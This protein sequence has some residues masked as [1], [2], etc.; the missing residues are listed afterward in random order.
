MTV[1]AGWEVRTFSASVVAAP[2][3]RVGP[4]TTAYSWRPASQ[5]STSSGRDTTCE[6]AGSAGA[7]T[8]AVVESG[9]TRIGMGG[10]FFDRWRGLVEEAG[11]RD[12]LGRRHL[13]LGVEQTEG[14]LTGLVAQQDLFGV[15]LRHGQGQQRLRQLFRA[16]GAV[17]GG[18]RLGRHG[19]GADAD[20]LDARQQ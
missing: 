10:S 14:E 6:P 16:L 11:G 20:H 13:G 7:S 3:S 5:P 12:A 9:S 1:V 2:V 17:A 19:G 18:G 15:L 8:P 4:R